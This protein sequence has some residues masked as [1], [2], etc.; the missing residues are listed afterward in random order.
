MYMSQSYRTL[1][2]VVLP[3]ETVILISQKDSKN[4]K[5]GPQGSQQENHDIRSS[6]ILDE[7][8]W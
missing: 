7:L 3:G 5:T 6:E 2:T 4:W 1:I 8:G